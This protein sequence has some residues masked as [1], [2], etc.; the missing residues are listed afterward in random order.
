LK[1]IG[2]EMVTALYGIGQVQG[3]E[4]TAIV[5]AA[6]LFLCVGAG[7]LFRCNRTVNARRRLMLGIGVTAS[8]CDVLMF[9]ILFPGGDYQNYGIGAAYG[10]LL[11]PAALVLVTVALTA[12][13]MDEG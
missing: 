4:L 1:G 8:C 9:V 13:N 3:S 6:C 7:F 10:A 12:W 11:Y 2:E 5:Y